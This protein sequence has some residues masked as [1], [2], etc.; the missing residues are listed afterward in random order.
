MPNIK[1]IRI[2]L[3]ATKIMEFILIKIL[4]KV[5]VLILSNIALNISVKLYA[6]SV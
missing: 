4:I 5:N 2:V 3:Y 6:K 1:M